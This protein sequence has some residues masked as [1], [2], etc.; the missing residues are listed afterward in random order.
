MAKLGSFCAALVA[1]SLAAAVE[2]AP[3]TVVMSLSGAAEFPSNASPGVGTAVITLDDD[4]DLFRVQ[5]TFSG[6]TGNTTMAHIHCCLVPP[7]PTV[8]VATELPSFTGFPLDVTSG[9]YDHT[10]DTTQDSTFN[11]AFLAAHVTAEGAADALFAGILAG[12]AYL[13]IHTT[14]FPA[15]EIRGFASP[16]PEPG[17]LA[18]VGVAALVG[19]S[20]RRRRR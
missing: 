11:P 18:L 3:I 16:V 2:A 1:A 17:S 4:A 20:L 8:S 7:A 14:A 12:R 6:L 5:A 19:L 13:N 9:T 10:F 15:G